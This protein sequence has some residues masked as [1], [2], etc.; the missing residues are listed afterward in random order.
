MVHNNIEHLFG[1]MCM[2][3]LTGILSNIVLPVMLLHDFNTVLDQ[4]HTSFTHA[5]GNPQ[6]TV[7]NASGSIMTKLQV[8]I[9][10]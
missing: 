10:L 8:R 3:G 5:A 7:H 2:H 9:H 1:E 6:L 4:P